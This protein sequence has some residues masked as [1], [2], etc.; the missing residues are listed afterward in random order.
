ML[1]CITNLQAEKLAEGSGGQRG[2]TKNTRDN[3]IVATGER[4]RVL[5][6]ALARYD[7]NRHLFNFSMCRLAAPEDV[8]K[9]L[10]LAREGG[11]TTCFEC[12]LEVAH[13]I[14]DRIASAHSDGKTLT[15][16]DLAGAAHQLSQ[17]LTLRNRKR[18]R[19]AAP[20]SRTCHGVERQPTEAQYFAHCLFALRT[21]K[22]HICFGEYRRRI[23]CIKNR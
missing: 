1:M 19:L 6:E 15:T 14:I 9:A 12:Y 2:Q 23:R 5:N 16:D 13:A 20:V 18:Q 21:Q 17:Y 3:A 8:A 10:D 4:V 7:A 22:V 11:Y